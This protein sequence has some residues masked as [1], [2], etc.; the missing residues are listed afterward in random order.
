MKKVKFLI[1]LLVITVVCDLVLLSTGARSR[2]IL[3]KY[4]ATVTSCKVNKDSDLGTFYNVGYEYKDLKGNF[5]SGT[6]KYYL[7]EVHE[8]DKIAV[9]EKVT[10]K[11]KYSGLVFYLTIVLDITL[12][13]LDVRLLLDNII[14]LREKKK[15][16]EEF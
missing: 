2:S 3:V 9:S 4:D 16:I 1:V 7:N 14:K 6:D 8:G 12:G 13:V 15:F 10:V 5:K 11:G